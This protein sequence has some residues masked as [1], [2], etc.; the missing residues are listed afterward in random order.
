MKPINGPVSALARATLES[1]SLP[2]LRLECSLAEAWPWPGLLVRA[3]AR[4]GERLVRLRQL[5]ADGEA[6]LYAGA[7]LT[8][9]PVD[10][11][12]VRTLRGLPCE[13]G[14]AFRVD[15]ERFAP[16]LAL[17][18]QASGALI[19]RETPRIAGLRVLGAPAERVLALERLENRSGLVLRA[20]PEFRCAEQGGSL[21]RP[22][23]RTGEW[24]VFERAV[25][26]ACEALGDPL[27]D[28][29]FE[30]APREVEGEAAWKLLHAAQ[31]ATPRLEVHL[32]AELA[33]A[34]AAARPPRP[35]LHV[36]ADPGIRAA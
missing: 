12:I 21:G 11:L 26:P 29:L 4:I 31:A 8:A 30:G 17:L 9:D 20:E 18:R 23:A 35:A 6:F 19:R 2:P 15:P 36:E 14:V 27:L 7:R 34:S 32:P 3:A 28:K 33:R 10:A 16:V 1:A 5:Q 24:L 22:L 25:A 13:D